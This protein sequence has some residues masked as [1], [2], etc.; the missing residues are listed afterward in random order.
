MTTIESANGP[1][2][3]NYTTIR[4]ISTPE[5]V[6]NGALTYS[7]VLDAKEIL[8]LGT[9][10]NLRTYIPEHNRK[11][12]SM[13]HR[14]IE[15]TIRDECD[16]FSQLNSGFLIG[17]S[18]A[19]LNDAEKHILIWDASINNGA[20][21]QGEI[22]LYHEECAENGNE[23]NKFN[24]RAEISIDPDSAMRTKI[25]IA[26]NTA[27]K[28]QGISSAGAQG[29]FDELAD[30]FAKENP[31]YRLAKKETDYGDDVV[32]TRQVLQILW[33]LMPDELAPASRSSV[34][35]RMR[36]YMNAASCLDDFTAVCDNRKTDEDSQRRYQYFLNMVGS[37][38]KLYEKWRTHPEWEKLRLLEGL[39]QVK[40]SK[41]GNVEKV[42]DGVLFPIIAALSKF[43]HFD[44]D[45][46]RWKYSPPA[47]FQDKMM[48]VAA[49][50]QLSALDG[51]PMLMGRSSSAYEALHTMTEMAAN[52]GASDT[53]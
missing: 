8:K 17:A 46:N 40:R 2:R 26:R 38:W 6:N 28:V 22:K 14:S 34:T 1:V 4:N 21:S 53:N 10:G 42:A 27:T 31:G 15:K 52:F 33:A 39:K 29:Y 44:S 7:V 20:Q 30:V 48:A 49:R 37:A 51:K 50:R 16:R 3:L 24:V 32:D 23:P 45:A 41:N 47:V 25:A 13:V 43:V 19:N 36:S 18:K 5:E 9:E 11:K 12:R 35:A